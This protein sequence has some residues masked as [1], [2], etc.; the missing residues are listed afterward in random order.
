MQT[1][2][3]EI[4]ILNIPNKKR[5]ITSRVDHHPKPKLKKK[6]FYISSSVRK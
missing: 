2:F 5:S 6:G 4:D 1:D 3:G